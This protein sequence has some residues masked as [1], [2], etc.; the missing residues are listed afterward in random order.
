M[1][2]RH[3]EGEEVLSVYGLSMPPMSGKPQ[4]RKGR[5]LCWRVIA[6]HFGMTVT[7][8]YAYQCP[9]GEILREPMTI[10]G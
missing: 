4:D 6:A 1:N 9:Y 2:L 5:Q 10:A 7:V 3:D 8:F